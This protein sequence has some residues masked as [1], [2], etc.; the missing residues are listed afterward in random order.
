VK[1]AWK[2]E[3]LPRWQAFGFGLWLAFACRIAHADPGAEQRAL[4]HFERGL[5]HAR[6][7]EVF[8]AA[9]EFE[10]AHRESPNYQVLYN[11]GQAY[12]LM[13]KPVEA[14]DALERYLA[15]GGARISPERREEVTGLIASER[16]RIGAVAL[17]VT[18]ASARLEVDGRAFEYT[19]TTVHVELVV[20]EHS[21]VASAPGYV[22]WVEK[23]GVEP[24]RTVLR[25]VEL[26]KLAASSRTTPP[27]TAASCAEPRRA[28]T[29]TA[30]P[31]AGREPS[32]AH[33]R[34]DSQRSWAFVTGGAGLSLAAGATALFIAGEMKHSDWE[35]QRAELAALPVDSP[36][37]L[38]L[39]QL[40]RLQET[41]DTVRTL[42][43]W[44]VGLTVASAA[45]LATS[46][47]LFL[48]RRAA[49][50]ELSAGISGATLRQRW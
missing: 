32:P 1:R 9:A 24:G 8:A 19:G 4:E 45:L 35:A 10:Q 6:S 26:V 42:D 47:T 7:G 16:Q 33:A 15:E 40:A 39:E 43:A 21:F 2:S 14:V 29:R 27:G 38:V 17:D 28:N 11:L 34:A 46:A 23:I 44:A 12:R 37:Q 30:L 36:P 22:P 20:G 49:A 50:L 13:G 3:S 25:T 31:P 5:A 48:S 41:G 18:P